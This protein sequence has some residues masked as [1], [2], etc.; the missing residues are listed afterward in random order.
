MENTIFTQAKQNRIFEDVIRQVQDAILDGVLKPGDK[1][2]AERELKEMLDVSRGTLREALRV[3]EIK[4]LI[5]IKTGV[6]GGA[7]VRKAKGP[8]RIP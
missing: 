5:T 4:G 2:P 8:C 3:L 1:L 6:N 7:I